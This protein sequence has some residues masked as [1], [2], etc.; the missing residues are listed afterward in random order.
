M[1]KSYIYNLLNSPKVD[2]ARLFNRKLY[3]LYLKFNFRPNPSLPTMTECNNSTTLQKCTC[4]SFCVLCINE[5][6]LSKSDQ[7]DSPNHSG[8]AL[9]ALALLIKKLC[10]HYIYR[11]WKQQ[12]V[13]SPDWKEQ[14]RIVKFLSLNLISPD[15][16]HQSDLTQE[17]KWACKQCFTDLTLP[18][19]FSLT[20]QKFPIKLLYIL[21]GIKW[22]YT[23]KNIQV[24]LRS[25]EEIVE[26]TSWLVILFSLFIFLLEVKH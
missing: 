13:C 23:D 9:T 8:T 11:D 7:S 17:D 2:A 24:A 22:F 21:L 1:L 16:G 10:Q 18:V 4:V 19:R 12:Q 15:L 25:K 20:S 14:F 26:V 5:S 6:N 3:K